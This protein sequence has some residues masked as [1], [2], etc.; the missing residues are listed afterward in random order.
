[1]QPLTLLAG[2]GAA[3]LITYFILK[4]NPGVKYALIKAIIWS[5]ARIKKTKTPIDPRL[6]ETMENFEKRGRDNDE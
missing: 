1:M 2:A 4:D 6:R 5:W 3:L